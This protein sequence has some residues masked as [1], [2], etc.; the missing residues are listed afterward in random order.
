MT[1]ANNKVY[2]DTSAFYALI[3]RSDRNHV[4]ASSIW[5]NLLEKQFNLVTTNYVVLDTLRLF[6]DDIGFEAASL[7]Y[8]DIL[9]VI[10][11]WW[12]D[13]DIHQRAYE[14]WLHLGRNSISLVDC[15]SFVAMHQHQ[16]E[17]AF[18]FKKHFTKYGFE[19]ISKASIS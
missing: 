17:K 13:A 10:E 2:V 3:N 12:F 11:V 1:F 8:R 6:Q 16:I 14:L 7:W 4:K 18:C 15:A 9:G 19:L 5:R